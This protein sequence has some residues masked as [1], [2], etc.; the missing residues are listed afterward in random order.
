M[1]Q[2]NTYSVLTLSGC[3]FQS[4]L[5]GK[6]ASMEITV[7]CPP[8]INIPDESDRQMAWERGQM[9]Y[10]GSDSFERIQCLLESKIGAGPKP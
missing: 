1:H 2:S 3:T 9:D 6:L 8:T 10:M 5:I 4:G 7:S